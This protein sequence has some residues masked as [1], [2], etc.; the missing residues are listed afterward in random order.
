MPGGE[1]YLVA[2]GHIPVE[3]EQ[4]NG[5]NKKKGLWSGIKQIFHAKPR[6]PNRQPR[7]QFSSDLSSMSYSCLGEARREEEEEY[8]RNQAARRLSRNLS[9]SHES[10]FQIEPNLIQVGLNLE[11][12]R[13]VFIGNASQTEPLFSV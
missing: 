13:N 1:E 9:L 3:E 10:V 4:G 11:G 6:R 2:L 8:M 12:S 7:R 5:F